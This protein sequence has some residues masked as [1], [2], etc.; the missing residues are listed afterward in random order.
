MRFS[1]KY[2]QINVEM[3]WGRGSVSLEGNSLQAGKVSFNIKRI[4]LNEFWLGL[5]ARKLYSL[6]QKFFRVCSNSVTKL[7]EHILLHRPIRRGYLQLILMIL[8]LTINHFQFWTHA[9]QIHV[10]K[11]ARA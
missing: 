9:L 3:G 6:N 11:E 4:C 5:Y 1:I 7:N 10:N 8:T 2:D